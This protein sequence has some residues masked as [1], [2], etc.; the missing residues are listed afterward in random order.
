M[1]TKT[2]LGCDRGYEWWLMT[3][4]KARNP[5]IKLYGLAW[6]APGWIGGGNFW[7]Q[8][9]VDYLLAWLGC[10]KNNGL[11]I[12]YLGG[13]NE[14]GYDINWYESL[15]TALASGGYSIKV[16]G[17]DS[18]W[19]ITNDM[20]SNATFK[21]SVDIVGVHY[22]C[23]GDGASATSCPA[24]ANG[25]TLGVPLWAS[26]NGSQ[27]LNG[28]APAMIRA[29]VRGYLDAKMTSFI[30]WPVIAAIPPGLPW[31][32]MGLVWTNVPWSGWYEIGLQT[33]ATA[34]V[35][36][37][38][39]PGWSFVD[40]AS[41][42]LG[43]NSA[44]GGY[45]T[46]K[47]PS[48]GDY[49]VIAETTT[50]T[51]PQTVSVKV[52]G[53]LSTGPVHVWTTNFGSSR[54]T[55]YFVHAGDVTPDGTGAY[56]V[57]LPPNVITTISTVSGQ[58]KGSAQSPAPLAAILPYS[59]SFEGYKVG[60]LAT[61][62]S[63]QS[64][65]FDVE[66]CGGGR[67]GQCLRQMAPTQ[68]IEWNSVEEPYN[69]IGTDDWADYDV[70][71]DAM[72]ESPGSLEVLGRFAGRNYGQ[73]AN[74]YGYFFSVSDTGAWSIVRGNN[75]NTRTT[76]ASG[77]ATALGTMTWH[78]LDFSLKG[79]AL[80][81]SVDGAMVGQAT[82]ATYTVGPAGLGVGLASG[83]WLDAQFDN[84][85]ITPLGPLSTP[86]TNTLVNRASGLALDV[87]GQSTSSGALLEQAAPSGGTSQAWQLAGDRSRYAVLLNANSQLAIGSP[88]PA[89]GG[90]VDQE[91]VD[92][93]A[94]QHFAVQPVDDT[95][96]RLV[97]PSGLAVSAA[98][99][100]TSVV[101]APL[102]CT[103]NSQQWSLAAS[104]TPN[105]AYAIQ[106][107]Q[108]GWVVDV[109]NNSTAAGG[110]VDQWPANGGGNQSWILTP[111]AG[112]GF[113]L[114]NVNSNL[115]LDVVGGNAEQATPSGAPSQ[116]WTLKAAATAGY[117]TFT[118]GAGGL[119]ESPSST[120]GA[121]LTVG[122]AGAGA[123]AAAQ[124][125]MLAASH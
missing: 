100:G 70:A 76:L 80:A 99:S 30:N 53:G 97:S 22:P 26:E 69:T 38:T 18:D 60:S 12:D 121:T 94:A 29:I 120:Q 74:L 15:H 71:V 54:S 6:G 55:D 106:N 10:A 40:S 49:T 48:G 111:A 47:A 107:H 78:H 23:G 108:T 63:D 104:P 68:P 91:T 66:A 72:L 46:L 44:N 16:V 33:W 83:T 56:W 124:E 103:S 43:G 7:S 122:A 79:S 67:S 3:E 36:Q 90:A 86:Y 24:N 105:A 13:W 21:S 59:D 11:S 88:G 27:D 45:V 96:Y 51:A 101:L 52:G 114:R 123:A 41:G 117:Y 34:Q 87:T 119:L 64:G 8:D 5:D 109:L 50:A 73:I 2:D 112:G 20:V 113:V 1:H 110:A 39:Q 42:Y 25:L 92:G 102:D 125:W 85:A 116:T 35:T 17:A 14:R 9:M 82:D 57:T 84:L 62:I 118:S 89:P 58:G 19:S 32:T 95:F 77:K 28:G 93:G 37:F 98:P 81:A 4:A 75:D 31:E 61:Y 65:A 115:A